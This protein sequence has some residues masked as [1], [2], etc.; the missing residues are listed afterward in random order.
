MKEQSRQADEQSIGRQEK[1]KRDTLEYEYQLKASL[2]Q[3]QLQEELRLK[4]ELSEKNQQFVTDLF[5]NAEKE[6]RETQKQNIMTVMNMLSYQTASAFS[7]TKLLYNAAYFSLMI[8]GA[9]HFTK[10]SS[11]MMGGM[12][13]SRFGKPQLIRETSKI[14]TNNYFMIP[15]MYTRKWMS[16][17]LFRS[18]E[19]KLLKGI[20]LDKK[21]ED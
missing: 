9:F 5:K 1:I 18:T 3:Q 17:G 15:W 4:K 10:M 2:K 7:N 12:L 20:I 14:Y 8:F 6:K 13:M 21:L 16:K 11:A 19:D